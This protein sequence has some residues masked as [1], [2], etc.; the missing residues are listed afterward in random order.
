MKIHIVNVGRS[1]YLNLREKPMGNV[2]IAIPCFKL[3]KV[4]HENEE[5]WSYIQCRIRGK[6]YEGYVFNRY[7]LELPQTTKKLRG[8]YVRK[9]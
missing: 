1:G 7:L 3:V 9:D 6:K 2:I 4:L 5:G 8:N